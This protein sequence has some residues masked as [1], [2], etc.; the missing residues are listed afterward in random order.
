MAERLRT[1]VLKFLEIFVVGLPERT[2]RRDGMVLQAA[3]GDIELGFIDAVRDE[4]VMDKALPPVGL[5]YRRLGDASVGSRR[6]HM[7]AI[8][9]FVH[10]VRMQ[11]YLLIIYRVVRRNLTSAL[12]IEDDADWDVQVKEQLYDYALTTRALFRDHSAYADPTFPRLQDP[13]SVPN[14]DFQCDKL[15]QTLEPKDSP[16]GDSWG[17]NLAR[18]LWHV[19][20]CS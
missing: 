10:Q 5:G 11:E 3:L 7:S 2:D 6:G 12:I 18:K 1:S 14:S 4:D 19:L 20:P 13:T 9:E 17:L 16:Y 8:R 15:P